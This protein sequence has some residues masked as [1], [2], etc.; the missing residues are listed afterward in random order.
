MKKREVTTDATETQRLVRDIY[1]QLHANKM[2]SLEG[3]DTF[4]ERSIS[5]D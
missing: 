2:G 1:K 4:L 5:Q 3:M